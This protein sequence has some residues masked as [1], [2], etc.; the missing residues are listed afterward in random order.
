MGLPRHAVRRVDGHRRHIR[1]FRGWLLRRRAAGALPDPPAP[2]PGPARPGRHALHRHLRR[3]ILLGQLHVHDS[4]AGAREGV[5]AVVPLRAGGQPGVERRGLRLLRLPLRVGHGRL[6]RGALA[7][8]AQERGREQGEDQPIHGLLPRHPGQH[9]DLH[10]DPHGHHGA[11][12]AR[13]A[14]CAALPPHRLHGRGVR[15]QHREPYPGPP[16]GHVRGGRQH[17]LLDRQQP[18]PRHPGQPDRRGVCWSVGRGALQLGV[19]YVQHKSAA[20][21]RLRLEDHP[22]VQG[23]AAGAVSGRRG[24]G[25]QAGAKHIVGQLIIVMGE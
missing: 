25:G 17:R 20:Q 14:H 3:R 10:R 11:R 1:L 4:G 2:G 23:A 16:W 12:Y 7:V 21:P 9:H 19:R 13:Q 8:V 6:Q 18:H 22:K 15:A 24:E 5:G